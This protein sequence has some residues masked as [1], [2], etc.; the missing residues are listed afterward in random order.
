MTFFL[1]V[2]SVIFGLL[3]IG[4]A[5]GWLLSQSIAHALALLAACVVCYVFSTIP[6]VPVP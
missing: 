3:A 2:A 4:E 1:R 5:N 6:P